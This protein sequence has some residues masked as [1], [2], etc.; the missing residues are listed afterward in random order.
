MASNEQSKQGIV[1]LGTGCAR[2]KKLEANVREALATLG[3]AVPVEHVTD[4]QQIAAYGVMMMPSLVID[5]KIVAVGK[6]LSVEELMPL[7]QKVRP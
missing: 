7:L 2:C 3:I 5:G 4:I 1:I 6:V